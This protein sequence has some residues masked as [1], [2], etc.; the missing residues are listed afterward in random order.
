MAFT[1][2]VALE[3][4][5]HDTSDIDDD[6][7]GVKYDENGQE[8]EIVDTRF[9]VKSK[10]FY[11]EDTINNQLFVSKWHILTVSCSQFRLIL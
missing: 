4:V 11:T 6:D 1:R 2:T 5:E 8:F 3:E 7:D 10:V 9:Q